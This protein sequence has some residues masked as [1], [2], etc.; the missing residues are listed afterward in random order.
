MTPTDTDALINDFQSTMQTL[1]KTRQE[2]SLWLPGALETLPTTLPA[3]QL[4]SRA[5]LTLQTGARVAL[6]FYVPP[7]TAR[8]QLQW[9]GKPGALKIEG[10]NLRPARAT[11]S[12]AS[13]ATFDFAQ[14]GW[15]RLVLSASDNAT[16]LSARLEAR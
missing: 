1:W 9:R 3:E 16:L 11:S 8:L 2:L 5:P 15:Q 7:N 13:A 10:L 6:R 14:N 4:A 12:D